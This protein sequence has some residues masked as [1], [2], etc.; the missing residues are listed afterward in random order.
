MIF[1]LVFWGMV[2]L[3]LVTLRLR[4][5]AHLGPLAPLRLS[6]GREGEGE[7]GERKREEE[8]RKRKEKE[9]ERKGEGEGGEK[10]KRKDRARAAA[11]GPRALSAPLASGPCFFLARALPFL[12]NL[13]LCLLMGWLGPFLSYSIRISIVIR[14]PYQVFLLTL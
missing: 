8:E 13:Y 4:R 3:R 6:R 7:G 9:R 10:E 5:K 14:Y 12:G 11:E 1:G 2:A